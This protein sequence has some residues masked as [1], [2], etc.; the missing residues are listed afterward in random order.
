MYYIIYYCNY[1]SAKH[2][3]CDK[4]TKTKHVFSDLAKL[5]KV[6]IIINSYVDGY[7]PLTEYFSLSCMSPEEQTSVS[8]LQLLLH[9]CLLQSF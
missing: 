5:I 7:S 1:T 9:P 8:S 2:I 4:D 6:G 3:Q